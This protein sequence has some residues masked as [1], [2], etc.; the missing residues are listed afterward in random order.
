MRLAWKQARFSTHPDHRM[1]AVIVKNGAVMAQAC[2]HSWRGSHAETRALGRNHAE[3]R[4][5]VRDRRPDDAYN[6]ATI[7]VVRANWGCS[8]PCDMCRDFIE[9]AKMKAV[10]YIDENRQFTKE[11]L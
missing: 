3:F 1:A 6:G 9:A 4:R 5:G 2:N 10:V 8:K 7:Y 11:W